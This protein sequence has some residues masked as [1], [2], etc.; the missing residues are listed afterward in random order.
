[1]GASGVSGSGKFVPPS[2]V[3]TPVTSEGVAPM[4]PLPGLGPQEPKPHSSYLDPDPDP[5]TEMA[6]TTKKEKR[7]SLGTVFKDM[8]DN[9]TAEDR[10]DSTST[11]PMGLETPEKKIGRLIFF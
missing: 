11:L 5:E 7:K 10:S 4:E 8:P 6:N 9:L 3:R 2:R 1:M